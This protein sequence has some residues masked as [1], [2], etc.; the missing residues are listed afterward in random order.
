M[1]TGENKNGILHQSLPNVTT[2][3]TNCQENYILNVA[4]MFIAL[5]F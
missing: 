4:L 3:K 2:P 5:P 1:G